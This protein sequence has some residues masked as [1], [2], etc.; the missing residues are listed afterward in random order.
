MRS[1][2]KRLGVLLVV[3]LGVS[4]QFDMMLRMFDPNGSWDV[5]VQ[6][7]H[8]IRPMLILSY[9]HKQ[10]ASYKVILM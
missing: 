6:A 3:T 8:W 10:T 7:L 4:K 2:E 1:K 5:L 9:L